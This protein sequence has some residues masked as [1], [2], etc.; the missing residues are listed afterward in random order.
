M[1]RRAARL[2]RTQWHD[3]R[4]RQ[5]L[6]PG[7]PRVNSPTTR[8][9]RMITAASAPSRTAPAAGA[10]SVALLLTLVTLAYLGASNLRLVGAAA[11]CMALAA[12]ALIAFRQPR[13]ATI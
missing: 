1:A 10:A 11:A 12:W 5:R 2:A 13:T 3:G 7:R 4:K 9:S 8:N 6:P